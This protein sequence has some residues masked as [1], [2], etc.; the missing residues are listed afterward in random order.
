[1]GQAK[2]EMM[3]WQELGCSPVGDKTICPDCVG[4]YA[5][6]QF[7]RDHG[8]HRNC[9]YCGQTYSSAKCAEADTLIEHIATSIGYEYEDPVHS[10]GYCSAE[11]G[12]LLPTM[13]SGDLLSHF[14]LGEFAED[15]ENSMDGLWVE[16]DPYGDRPWEAMLSSWGAFAHYVKHRQR[17]FF[18]RAPSSPHDDE[19]PNASILDQIASVADEAGLLKKLPVGTTLYRSRQ[20][21]AGVTLNIATDLGTPPAALAVFSNR[22]SPAGIPMFYAAKD[23][24]TARA[25]TEVVDPSQA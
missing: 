19:T 3:K 18:P 20:H 8:L 24:A 11:G 15:A 12:Y 4:D 10:V 2:R 22:M 13:D 6:K 5:L 9:D 21:V 25:E 17:F 1:M 7:I 23:P 14:E 16:S